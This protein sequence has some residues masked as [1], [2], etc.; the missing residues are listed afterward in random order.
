VFFSPDRIRIF[1]ETLVAAKQ[2]KFSFEFSL[3]KLRFSKNWRPMLAIELSDLKIKAKD[4]CIT[5]STIQI[6][7][8]IVPLDLFSIFKTNVQLGT[9]SV[10]HLKLY[11]R[12]KECIKTPIENR[13][14]ETG[15]VSL[16]RFFQKRWSK[17]IVNTTRFLKEFSVATIEI[18]ENEKNISPIV[19]QDF[20]MNFYSAGKDKQSEANFS[21]KLDSTW[22][23]KAPLGQITVSTII[24][25]NE[26]QLRSN[27]NLKEGQFQIGAR[28]AIDR[29]E[30]SSKFS[31]QDIPIQNILDLAH[32]W[33]ILSKITPAIKNQWANCDISISGSV[34]NILDQPLKLHQCRMYGDLGEI[35]IETENLKSLRE[36]GT[37]EFQIQNIS[38]KNMLSAFQLDKTWG[39]VSNFGNYS[40]VFKILNKNDVELSGNLK[41]IELY[42][43]GLKEHAKLRIDA[44]ALNAEMKSGG[45]ALKAMDFEIEKK[46]NQISFNT[47]L[48][49]NG[50][51]EAKLNIEGEVFSDETQRKLFAGHIPGA[52]SVSGRSVVKDFKFTKIAG[53]LA[54]NNFQTYNWEMLGIKILPNFENDKWSFQVKA[55]LFQLRP[56]SK[57][58]DFFNSLRVT[59]LN[60]V[61]GAVLENISFDSDYNLNGNNIW[62]WKGFSASLRKSSIKYFSEGGG[63]DQGEVSGSIRALA[64]NKT[65]RWDLSGSW[66]EPKAKLKTDKK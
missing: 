42:L 16:E 18:I 33:N 21:V 52:L 22:V 32:H 62:N 8:I 38:L 37:L 46:Q 1:V 23:G 66:T 53:V 13:D 54:V 10:D 55:N 60:S 2:P 9:V 20:N 47:T 15:F 57:W 58:V 24:K 59:G 49:S 35:Y 11:Y 50:S 43:P 51:G 45:F 30:V 44:L 27:G 29:G 48:D 56:E 28:W 19:I 61:Q 36:G 3:A 7:S 25:E 12:E 41:D 17:E 34:Y 63:S 31:S 5:N 64:P 4:P 39:F 65:T 26:L 40:G 6:N 14:E